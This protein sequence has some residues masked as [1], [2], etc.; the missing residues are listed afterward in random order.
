M[1]LPAICVEEP[2]A[3]ELVSEIVRLAKNL[4]MGPA[5]D[6]ATELGPLVTEEHRRSVIDWIEQGVR[7]GAKLVLDG[8]SVTVKGFEKG[9]FLGATIFDHVKP[10]MRIGIDE[11]FGPVLSVKRVKDFE[12]GLAVMN[13]S[14]YGNGSSIF[15]LNGHYA[16]EFTQRTEAGM[17]GVNVGIPVPIS[18][19]P[20]CGHKKSFLGDLHVM[21]RDGVAFFT[22]TRSVTTYWFMEKDFT[23]EK[24]GTWEGTIARK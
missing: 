23:N 12:D 19:F 11:I 16:R 5:W 17:V 20:F 15:T 14:E 1:A 8:R 18:V 22:E 3:D 9:F 24:V 6:S 2:I 4:K 7:E 21:G 13:A 10:G